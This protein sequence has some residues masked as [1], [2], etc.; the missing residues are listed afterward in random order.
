MELILKETVN[1]QRL[2][3]LIASSFINEDEKKQLKKYRKKINKEDSSVTVVYTNR[4]GMG[5]KY[6]EGSLS[7]QNFRKA[8]RLTLCYDTKTDI[9]MVNCHPVLMSQYCKKNNIRCEMLDDYIVNREVR[10][11]EIMTTCSIS[12]GEAKNMVLI[13]M[14]LGDLNNYC[15]TSGIA[16]PPPDWVDDLAKCF[17]DTSDMIVSQNQDVFKK[18]SASRSTDHKNKKA[19]TVSYVIQIIEDNL[20]MNAR[21]KL[22]ELGYYVET[23]CF[24][25]LLIKKVDLQE[26]LM[27]ELQTY[28]FDKTGYNI[29]FEVKPM[30]K[31][32]ELDDEID[33]DFSSYD[34]ENTTQYNQLYCS[35]L[36]GSSQRNTYLIRKAYI[37]LFLCKV[38]T[39][40]ACFI[41]QNGEVTDN[42]VTPVPFIFAAQMVTCLLKPIQSGIFSDMGAPISFYDIWSADPTMR[43]YRKYD[44]MPYNSVPPCGD[45]YNMFAGF[46]PHCVVGDAVD[47]KVLNVWFDLCKALCGDNDEHALY[48]QQFLAN[49]FQEPCK[50]PP[51]ALVFKGKQGTG[52]N[53]VLDAIGNMLNSDH[54]TTSSNPRDFFGDHAEGFYRKLLVN[55]NE[56][57]GKDTFDFEGRIK[58][59]VTE[60][61]I[62]M[63]PKFVRPTSVSNHARLIITTNKPT[64]IPIDVKSRDRRYVVY[65]TSDRYLQYDRATWDNIY[66]HLRKPAFIATLYDYYMKLDLSKVDWINDRPITKAY[67]EMC[68]LFSPT[69][70]LFFEDYIDNARWVSNEIDEDEEPKFGTLKPEPRKDVEISI[71]ASNLFVA[72]ETFCRTNRFTKENNSPNSRAFIGRLDN[73]ELPLTRMKVN[74]SLVWKFVPNSVIEF[75]TAK[76]WIN[77]YG[78][79]EVESVPK[80][81]MDMETFM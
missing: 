75:M 76:R 29:A 4:M 74:H 40:D 12:R 41:F 64:P 37:E 44:F 59:F 14:Y 32:I 72:Y 20:V 3:A 9:D 36:E 33:T 47:N 10:L 55:I 42:M 1:K 67:R 18:V 80:V 24:D 71:S 5:R 43:I 6:A 35:K 21:N 81:S 49:I 28:C 45:I 17:I 23:L 65:Q 58:S 8:I 62:Q 46:N 70:A 69:E 56:A 31:A 79:D 27:L 7:Y 51:V 39:P 22:S 60:P 2:S 68:N 25:G 34:F 16:T 50:R 53:M 77:D 63:N 15:I 11:N 78:M 61:T 19:S 66:K 13:L 30:H 52:K 73:L 54:Y 38:I 48:F 57:E 26:D